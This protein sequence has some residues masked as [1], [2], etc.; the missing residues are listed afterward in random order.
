MWIIVSD[1][2][3]EPLDDLPPIDLRPEFARRGVDLFALPEGSATVVCGDGARAARRWLTDVEGV[4]G[5]A[6]FHL[7]DPDLE[8]CLAWSVPGRAFGF[9]EM[10]TERGTQA[11]PRTRTRVAS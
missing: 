7:T 2:D 8:C 3:Q 4:E 5:T 1:H 10:G 9:A 6:P 11:A